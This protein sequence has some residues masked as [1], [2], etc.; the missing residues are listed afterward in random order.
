MI[1][2]D[3]VYLVKNISNRNSRK[4]ANSWKTNNSLLNEEWVK[5]EI[6]A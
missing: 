2:K 3:T 1:G 6:K 5:T 4:Y